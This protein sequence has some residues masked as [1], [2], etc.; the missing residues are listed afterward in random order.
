MH[1]IENREEEMRL[2]SVIIP[3]YNA[4]EYLSKC[5]ESVQR[6][7]LRQIEIICI[8]DGSTDN[9]LEILRRFADGDGRI[10]IIHQKNSGAGPAR[11]SGLDVARGEY[12]GF[13]DPDDWYPSD[14]TLENLYSKARREDA[15]IC[16]GSLSKYIDGVVSTDFAAN[17]V[18]YTFAK[19]GRIEYSDYQF[20]YG[21][22]R[23]IYKRTLLEDCKIR[24]PG[25]WRF[26]D[27]PFFVAAM[28]AAG[29]FY[30]VPETTYV[31]RSGHKT[32]KWSGRDS[33]RILD[34]IEGLRMNLE[35][36]S[37][38]GLW[39]LHALTTRRIEEDFRRRFAIC[40]SSNIE[41]YAAL[42]RLNSFIDFDRQ[43][44]SGDEA[45]KVRVISPLVD[46]WSGSIPPESR[47]VR[48]IFWPFR[49]ANRFVRSMRTEP[50]STT[51]RRVVSAIRHP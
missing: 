26:Q 31:Y 42:L 15:S 47:V 33:R 8:D 12:V 44:A 5:L 25:L 14:A 27:P 17:N 24:F 34:S 38:N 6:Q 21:Y 11:N 37:S 36:S 19:E 48:V 51:L 39:K 49:M 22:F 41:V 13:M 45:P 46:I 3:V 1:E 29:W 16:G 32:I 2:V 9:S 30:A 23:F 18:N 50:F 43:E 28:H 4:S 20:D 7:T 35:F 40:G 10:V